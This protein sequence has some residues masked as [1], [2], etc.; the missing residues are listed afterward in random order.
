MKA[1]SVLPQVAPLRHFNSTHS[2]A[3]GPKKTP[4][5]IAWLNIKARCLRETSTYY[6]D[7]GGRGI[8]VC[9]RWI[10]SFENFL[11]DMGEIPSNKHTIERKD[12]N[13]NY[14]PDNCYWATRKEQAN[15]RR[16]NVFIEFNNQ[17]KTIAQWADSVG[18][19]MKT[20]HK[21][22]SDGWSFES[23]ITTPVR[24]VRGNPPSD[25]VT[26]TQR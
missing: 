5:Y 9:A 15:N 10:N 18:I 6:H 24:K 20:L 26:P 3:S 1:E 12:N 13:G 8:T 11:K 16:S 2:Y 4:I 23:A 19:Q 7:Y 22:I 21:R 17:K 14:E 25:V